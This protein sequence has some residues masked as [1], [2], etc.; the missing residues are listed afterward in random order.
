MISASHTLASWAAVR[1]S[2]VLRFLNTVR[3]RVP[4]VWLLLLLVCWLKSYANG[5]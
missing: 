2:E 1:S 3:V 5:Y 4:N